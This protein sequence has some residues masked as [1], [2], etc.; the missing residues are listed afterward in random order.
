[1]CNKIVAGNLEIFSWSQACD[2]RNE[3]FPSIAEKTMSTQGISIVPEGSLLSSSSEATIA[4]R[5][6][7]ACPGARPGA[8]VDMS[9]L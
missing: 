9:S 4:V 5:M 3:D 7:G 1:M 8:A 2:R 6:H